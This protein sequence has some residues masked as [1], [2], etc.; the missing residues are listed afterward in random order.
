MDGMS[1]GRGRPFPVRPLAA[2]ALIM[3]VLSG[4]SLDRADKL[5]SIGGL[6]VALTAL[7]YSYRNSNGGAS[8]NNEAPTNPVPPVE[9]HRA[10]VGPLVYHQINQLRR[11]LLGGPRIPLAVAV[12]ATAAVG[13]IGVT[14][15]YIFSSPDQ[16]SAGTA[17]IPPV[18]STL[19]APQ[20]SP[21]VTA[22]ISAAVWDCQW[23]GVLPTVSAS[24][25]TVWRHARMT[26]PALYSADLD[27]PCPD[28]DIAGDSESS[29]HDIVNDGTGIFREVNTEIAR[30]SGKMPGTYAMCLGNT[31]YLAGAVEYDMLKPGDRYCVKTIDRSSSRQSL[32][33]VVSVQRSGEA[34]TV[35][36]D[37]QTWA[38]TEA[39]SQDNDD[40]FTILFWIVIAAIFF[41]GGG[42]TA[43]SQRKK[44][45]KK[46][47]GGRR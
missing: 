17:T 15:T 31:D 22:S 27:S 34:R 35:V 26:L 4:L 47:N 20:T 43:A 1:G 18:S 3:I 21:S 32:L 2:A 40:V 44:P 25:G 23:S 13:L 10:G 37:V 28:W 41:G 16:P 42:A 19:A 7:L 9:P 36:F 38:T 6:F 8:G 5:A 12:T 30:V 24:T 45:R 29:L 11:L 39:S 33:T 46:R 14:A